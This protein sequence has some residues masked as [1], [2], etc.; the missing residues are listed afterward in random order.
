VGGLDV[1]STDQRE[2]RGFLGGDARDGRREFFPVA[3][4]IKGLESVQS[5]YRAALYPRFCRISRQLRLY[6]TLLG[7]SRCTLGH[8]GFAMPALILKPLAMRHVVALV[9]KGNSVADFVPEVWLVFPTLDVVG[10]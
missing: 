10:V 5:C 1:L 6:L 4:S 9:A 2:E 8:F 7:E 3:D